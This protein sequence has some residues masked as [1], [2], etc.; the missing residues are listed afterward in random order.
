M[1]DI[2]KTVHGILQTTPLRWA[3]L[4]QSV[5][6]E[7]LTVNPA[8]GEWSALECIQHILDTEKVFLKISSNGDRR[9]FCTVPIV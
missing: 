6:L 2:L 5:S 7:I 1:S 4:T 3:D 8:P 9:Y